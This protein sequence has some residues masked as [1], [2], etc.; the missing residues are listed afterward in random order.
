MVA[1]GA[2]G[3]DDSNGEI[4]HG[5]A[6]EGE[7]GFANFS[8]SSQTQI[9]DRIAP[10]GTQ[11]SVGLCTQPGCIPGGFGI[12]ETN[13]DSTDSGG[14]GGGGYYAGATYDGSGNG[15]GGS[16]FISGHEPCNAIDIASTENNIIPSNNSTHY[17]GLRFH[18]TYMES[19]KVT[20]YKMAGKVEI[21]ILLAQ[22][23][24]M[25]QISLKTYFF[26]IFL[27]LSS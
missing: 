11:T 3:C 17:S 10:G 22:F 14:F 24:C 9:E 26:S 4:G 27:F 2:G 7:R 12:A 25:H 16:S 20:L 18:D 15:G 23:T 8:R 5:G 13:P 21:T 1:G 6:L 19:G